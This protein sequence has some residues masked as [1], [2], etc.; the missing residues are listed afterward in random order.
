M[1]GSITFASLKGNV[2]QVT[3]TITR[4]NGPRATRVVLC[5]Q[6]GLSVLV[7]GHL[8]GVGSSIVQKDVPGAQGSVNG[9]CLEHD[10]SHW[11]SS[12]LVDTL[13]EKVRQNGQVP[14][15]NL[16]ETLLDASAHN[17]RS[18]GSTTNGIL[19]QP[20]DTRLALPVALFT[21]LF[22]ACI[23]AGKLGKCRGIQQRQALAGIATQI[24]VALVLTL[25]VV[26]LLN[27]R[28]F[29]H[30]R[31]WNGHALLRLKIAVALFL[32]HASNPSCTKK[33]F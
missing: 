13:P 15:A 8:L 12:L 2:G 5:D 29:I 19:V 25:L 21:N 30:C 32:R 16:L 23:L 1:D 26:L 3:T 17:D 6:V 20:L 22:T 33:K 14:V 11:V 9:T 31:W 7:S 4:R 10:A 24:L 27:G 28:R 18:N